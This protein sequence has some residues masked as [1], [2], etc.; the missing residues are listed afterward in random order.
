MNLLNFHQIT[1][2]FNGWEGKH[3]FAP[4]EKIV[5]LDL[6]LSIDIFLFKLP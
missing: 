1:Y 2:I 5:F 3:F 6:K 4:P